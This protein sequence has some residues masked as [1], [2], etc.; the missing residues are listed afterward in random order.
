[1]FRRILIEDWTVIFTIV[2]FITVAS[3]YLTMLYRTLRLK[4]K[5]VDHL[6]HLPFADDADDV[7]T[8]SKSSSRHE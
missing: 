7:K 2:A 1:M 4:K 6:S 5:E 3:I 8:P